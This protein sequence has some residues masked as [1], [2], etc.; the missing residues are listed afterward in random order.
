MFSLNVHRN[1]MHIDRNAHLQTIWDSHTNFYLFKLNLTNLWRVKKGGLAF[2]FGWIVNSVKCVLKV[3]FALSQNIFQLLFFSLVHS[4][5]VWRTT[6]L[7]LI[8][9][10]QGDGI[11]WCFSSGTLRWRHH[12]SRFAAQVWNLECESSRKCPGSRKSESSRKSCSEANRIST[13]TT[14][15]KDRPAW[16]TTTKEATAK[17][18]TVAGTATVRFTD[19]NHLWGLVLWWVAISESSLLHVATIFFKYWHEAY[20]SKVNNQYKLHSHN[21]HN[22]YRIGTVTARIQSNGEKLCL[23][24]GLELTTLRSTMTNDNSDS[25]F[26]ASLVPLYSGCLVWSS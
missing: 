16:A 2:I 17:A 4:S 10:I 14:V 24:M 22:L 12:R 1:L 3:Y 6:W 21:S 5:D 9:A 18:T 15:K 23:A 25:V 20:I 8:V 13:T 26:L 7:R 19:G 11:W